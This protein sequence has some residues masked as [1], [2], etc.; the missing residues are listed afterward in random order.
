MPTRVA[1]LPADRAAG[2]TAVAVRFGPRITYRL[3]VV[4]WTVALSGA[5]V[6]AWLDVFVPRATRPYQ[7]MMA[8]VLIGAYAALTRRP[9]TL[10][11]ACLAALFIVP[12]LGFIIGYINR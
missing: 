6:C 5:L 2:D 9:S 10:R 11:L 8:P 4:L 12:T 1:D 3:G 7:I